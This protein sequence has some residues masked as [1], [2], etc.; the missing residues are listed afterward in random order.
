MKKCGRCNTNPRH[1][2]EHFCKECIP[3]LFVE[4]TERFPD[5]ECVKQIS[6][7][8]R[9]TGRRKVIIKTIETGTLCKMHP[10]WTTDEVVFINDGSDRMWHGFDREKFEQ[11]FTL[12]EQMILF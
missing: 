9:E 3:I 4:L 1:K 8:Y 6:F 10:K 11:H 5:Y 12:R 7:E 2:F